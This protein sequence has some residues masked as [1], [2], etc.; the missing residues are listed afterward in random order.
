MPT[1]VSA[2]TVVFLL[3][4]H[5]DQREYGHPE[6]RGYAWVPNDGGQGRQEQYDERQTHSNQRPPGCGYAGIRD[7][8]GWQRRPIL[9]APP[10][11]FRPT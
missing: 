6:Q 3:P 7:D 5:S 4:T 10:T 8:R 11:A 1:T 9:S 2:D